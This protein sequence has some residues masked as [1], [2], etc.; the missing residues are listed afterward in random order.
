MENKKKGGDIVK[1]LKVR[2][3]DHGRTTRLNARSLFNK[4][5]E[6]R[7]HDIK[8]GAH[9]DPVYNCLARTVIILVCINLY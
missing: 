8:N 3:N 5:T 6:T 9:N 2:E 4:I 1:T 7:N